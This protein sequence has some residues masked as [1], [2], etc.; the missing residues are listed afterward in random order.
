MVLAKIL[1]ALYTVKRKSES[2]RKEKNEKINKRS[3][4]YIGYAKA[5]N[6]EI[7]YCF[8]PELR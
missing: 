6:V 5:Y 4:A 8:N 1:I 2:I 7:L 3:R